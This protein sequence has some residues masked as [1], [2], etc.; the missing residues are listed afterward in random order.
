[1]YV[2]VMKKG[3]SVG[4]MK[5]QQHYPQWEQ[6]ANKLVNDVTISNSKVLVGATSVLSPDELDNLWIDEGPISLMIDFGYFV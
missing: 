2:R 6:F 1:M 5:N 4:K 3:R